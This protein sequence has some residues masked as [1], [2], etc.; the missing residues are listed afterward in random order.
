MTQGLI[1][2]AAESSQTEKPPA[3]SSYLNI[4]LTNGSFILTPNL[5]YSPWFLFRGEVLAVGWID[6]KLG[7]GSGKPWQAY[8]EIVFECESDTIQGTISWSDPSVRGTITVLPDGL[9]L[10]RGETEVNFMVKYVPVNERQLRNL[11]I[12]R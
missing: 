3:F 12:E 6:M 9:K 5:T 2:V 7:L 10:E 8:G 11:K 4:T 1:I